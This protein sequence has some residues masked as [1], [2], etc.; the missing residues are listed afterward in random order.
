MNYKQLED[1]EVLGESL[2]HYHCV[3]SESLGLNPGFRVERSATDCLIRG[4][5]ILSLKCIN[6]SSA[7]L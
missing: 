2:F 3:C 5:A 4:M 6:I 7:S 1:A